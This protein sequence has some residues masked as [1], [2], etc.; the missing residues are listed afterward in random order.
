LVGWEEWYYRHSDQ[1]AASEIAAY[2]KLVLLQGKGVA[3]CYG[4]G[5]L[6]LPGRVIAPRVL[7]LEYLSSAITL[8]DVPCNLIT[9]EAIESLVSTVAS[10][11]SLGVTHCD[12]NDT[13]VL[14]VPGPN[15]I[16][17][18]VIV[19]FGSSFTHE[20]ESEDK[21][22]QIVEQEQDV[23]WLKIQLRD[24]LRREI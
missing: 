23:R 12:L 5:T 19:D 21:W 13:N 14:I 18:S 24:K 11:G 3:K 7:I 4:S 15:G 17:C 9:D 10:F 22:K 20:D 6:N 1:A 16:K 2:T 8:K